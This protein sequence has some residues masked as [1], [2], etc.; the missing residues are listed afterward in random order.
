[1]GKERRIALFCV[2]LHEGLMTRND[3]SH[4]EREILQAATE[5]AVELYDR[6]YDVAEKAYEAIEDTADFYLSKPPVFEY[7]VIS[8]LGEDIG[9]HVAAGRALDEIFANKSVYLMVM[10]RVQRYAEEKHAMFADSE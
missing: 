7:T 2:F 1:M 8:K 3:G 4:R 6:L 5:G 9:D 10:D